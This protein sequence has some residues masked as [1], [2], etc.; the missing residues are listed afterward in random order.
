MDRTSRIPRPRSMNELRDAL[1]DPQY[2]LTVNSLGSI[3]ME[4]LYKSESFKTTRRKSYPK[5]HN[6]NV[7]VGTK[8]T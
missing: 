4:N 5:L 7:S 6:S 3:S 2:Q 1:S 8:T